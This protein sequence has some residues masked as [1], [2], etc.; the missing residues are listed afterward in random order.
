MEYRTIDAVL[1]VS[2]SIRLVMLAYTSV[3]LN[4][5]LPRLNL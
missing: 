5:S 3:L 4:F 2:T 1:I